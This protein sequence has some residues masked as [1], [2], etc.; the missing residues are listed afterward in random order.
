[1]KK[2]PSDNNSRS[3]ITIISKRTVSSN[4]SIIKSKLP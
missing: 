4:S 1:M 3:I 2:W